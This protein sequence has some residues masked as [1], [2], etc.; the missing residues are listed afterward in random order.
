MGPVTPTRLPHHDPRL[1]GLV[2]LG[3]AVGSVLRYAVS[4]VTPQPQGWPL[5]TLAVNVV[6]AFALGL[7]LEG[8]ARR[9]PETPARRR[10]RLT[11]GTGLLGGFTTYSSLALEV[12]RLLSDGAVG[13]AVGYAAATLLAGTVAA[14]VGVALGV[15]L[16]QRPRPARVPVHDDGVAR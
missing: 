3:G 11:L 14:V 4:L 1:L 13:V 7:L 15:R 2:T 8:L 9:G 12:E 6:G 5:G 16:P 10:V